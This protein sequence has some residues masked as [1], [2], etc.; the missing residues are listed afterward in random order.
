MLYVVS[1]LV[2]VIIF[3]LILSMR[4]SKN[5][6][7][8]NHNKMQLDFESKMNRVQLESVEEER[9]RL[10]SVLH[11]D[12]GQIITLVQMQ[13]SSLTGRPNDLRIDDKT[14]K[15]LRELIASASD[16]CSSI[17]KMLFP[18]S[19]MRLG[20]IAGLQELICDVQL[21]A[22]IHIDFKYVE[23]VL[24]DENATNLYRIFQELLNNTVKHA[25]ATNIFIC[26][27]NT[28]DGIEVEYKDNGI[29]LQPGKIK[30][31]LG[32][33]TI[34]TRIHV[35]QGRIM[36]TNM[37]KGYQIKFILPNGKN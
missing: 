29:G 27:N 25:H 22:K 8:L 24:T 31:G 23:F 9:R 32:M 7:L 15:L 6:V 35:L 33:T 34:R 14:L 10:G 36:T 3:A 37:H 17:S 20:I 4:H 30:E 1:L 11:D 5:R 19:L 12:L 21:A 26:I 18:A 13:L 28:S 16:K 2:L